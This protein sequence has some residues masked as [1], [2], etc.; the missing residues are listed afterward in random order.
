MIKDLRFSEPLRVHLEEQHEHP[1]PDMFARKFESLFFIIISLP[2][3]NS[4][5]QLFPHFKRDAT[6]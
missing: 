6:D 2:G 3:F 4:D 5:L 1:P